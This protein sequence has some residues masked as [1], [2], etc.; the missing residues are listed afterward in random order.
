MN[1]FHRCTDLFPVMTLDEKEKLVDAILKGA[2]VDRD[3]VVEF[4]FYVGE[5]TSNVVQNAKEWLP[6]FDFCTT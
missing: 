3:K 1:L 5:D 2:T 4:E 6:E